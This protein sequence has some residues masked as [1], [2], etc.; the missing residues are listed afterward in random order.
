M[1][2]QEI[3]NTVYAHLL[4]Q[5]ARAQRANGMCAY[6]SPEGNRCAVGCLFTEEEYVPAMEGDDPLGLQHRGLLP[7][8]LVPHRLLLEDLQAIHDGS[9]PP[10]W[11][12]R[13]TGLARAHNLEVPT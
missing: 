6:L 13:L 11:P 4:K 1:T 3:F 5:N 12:R 7:D 2:A 9:P 10:E 8:R